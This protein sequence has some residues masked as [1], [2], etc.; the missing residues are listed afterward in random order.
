MALQINNKHKAK[1][2]SYNSASVKSA[3][4]GTLTTSKK[5][6]VLSKKGNWAKIQLKNGK[7]G[8]VTLSKLTFA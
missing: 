2:A 1:A 3:K 7:T 5:V 4:I 8:Y 6:K